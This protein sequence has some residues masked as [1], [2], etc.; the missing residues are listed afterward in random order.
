MRPDVK[1]KQAVGDFL[2]Q[3]ICFESHNLVVQKEFE[4]ARSHKLRVWKS[5]CCLCPVVVPAFCSCLSSSDTL[6][7]NKSWSAVLWFTICSEWSVRSWSCILL[8]DGDKE[9]V[10]FFFMW[11]FVPVTVSIIISDFHFAQCFYDPTWN[12]I[13]GGSSTL[14]CWKW[15]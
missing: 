13:P 6:M 4:T 1:H 3:M 8:V 14:K 12:C 11:P 9:D 10:F 5:L 2:I 7:V 15:V